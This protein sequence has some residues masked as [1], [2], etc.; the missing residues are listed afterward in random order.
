MLNKLKKGFTLIELLVVM[1]I[2]AILAAVVFAAVNPG[3]QFSQARD[4]QRRADLN[5]IVSA[6]YQYA[7]DNNGNLPTN[8]PTGPTNI[9][10]GAGNYDLGSYLT[11]TYVAEI[12]NDPSTGTSAN[13]QYLIFQ[14]NNGRVIAS[15]SGEITATISVNR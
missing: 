11:P 14:D 15:A 5:T 9:G 13:T 8:F 10:S 2:I 6:V 4:T 12:P 7:V 3:R 1:G